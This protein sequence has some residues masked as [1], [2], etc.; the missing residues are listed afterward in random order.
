MK[1]IHTSVHT[2]KTADGHDVRYARL[3]YQTARGYVGQSMLLSRLTPELRAVADSGELVM[4]GKR[5]P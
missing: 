3:G 2:M 1:L 4:L 5:A